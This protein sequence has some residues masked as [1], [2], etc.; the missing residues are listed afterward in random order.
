[1]S[2]GNSKW[3]DN[4][5]SQFTRLCA[6]AEKYAFIFIIFQQKNR[7]KYTPSESFEHPQFYRQFIR[8]T[9]VDN[10][11]DGISLKQ[12]ADILNPY[13]QQIITC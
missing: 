9:D 1:M 13:A 8:E 3:S 10:Y 6:H 2:A 5:S 4:S 11:K 12:F 7:N